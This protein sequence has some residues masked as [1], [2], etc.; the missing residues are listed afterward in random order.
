VNATPKPILF[1]VV[2][3]IAALS[4]IGLVALCLTMFYKNYADPSVLSS[5]IAIEGG[6]VGSLGTLLSNMRQP[7]P[8]NGSGG[9]G[10]VT[11]TIEAT[12]P[13]TPAP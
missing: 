3:T 1:I 13:T 12:A 4:T 10:T 8:T 6:L 5:L 9:G 2:G 7:P 11:A